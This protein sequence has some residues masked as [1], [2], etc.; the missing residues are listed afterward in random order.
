MFYLLST[1][2]KKKI[3]QEYYSKVF[4]LLTTCLFITLVI[5]VC[6]AAPTI[7][8]V[9]SELTSL[10]LA[11]QP[12]QDQISTMKVEVAKEDV[13][14]ILADV[15]ILSLPPKPDI[16]KIYVRLIEVVES[17][18][19]AK[20]QTVSVDTLTKT[21]KANLYVRDKDVAEALVKKITEEKYLG[22]DLPY[23][24]LSQKSSFTF[25]QTLNYENL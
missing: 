1:P 6:L 22:A 17:V 12:L 13:S 19:G 20:I 10:N 18:P 14:K 23:T 9:Y 7:I 24:V 2:Q 25:P 15:D 11:I 5:A 3:K 16:S 8:K 4:R 21:I